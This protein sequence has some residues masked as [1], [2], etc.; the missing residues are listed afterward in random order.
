MYSK[1]NGDDRITA[2][3]DMVTAVLRMTRLQSFLPP[4]L[5]ALIGRDEEFSYFHLEM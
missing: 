4:E 1:L 2:L 5:G 3:G